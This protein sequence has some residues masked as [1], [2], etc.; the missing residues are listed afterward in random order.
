MCVCVW[1]VGLVGWLVCVA[2]QAYIC[3]CARVHLCRVHVHLTMQ[4]Y[5]IADAGGWGLSVYGV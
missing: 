2:V 5:M 1:L 3:A 4:C